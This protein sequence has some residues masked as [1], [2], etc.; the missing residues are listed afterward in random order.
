M[1][2]CKDLPPCTD[3]I[4]KK[5]MVQMPTLNLKANNDSQKRVKEYLEQSA[6]DMLADKINFGIEIEKDGKTLVNKK[7]LD[8]FMKYATEEARKIAEK[9]SQYACVDDAT[10]FGWA[11]HY[12]EEDSIV[13]KLYN[14]DGT[15]YQVKKPAPKKTKPAE[16]KKPDIKKPEPKPAEKPTPSKV[17]FLN[18]VS[19]FDL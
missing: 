13:E 16:T 6:S 3:E 2:V 10:V 14:E 9:G 17:T 8:G 18:Q 19:I 1:P 5:G 12:F 11:I 4:G 15:E 7:T